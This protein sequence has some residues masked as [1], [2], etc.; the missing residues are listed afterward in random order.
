MV[1]TNAQINNFFTNNAQLAIPAETFDQLANEGITAPDDLT[2]FDK[3]TMK[4]VVE[5][6]RNPGGR[7]PNPDPN[8]PDG[9]TIARPPFV[10]GAKS[11]KRILE[12]CDIICFYETI[13][14]PLDARNLVY[15]TI[16]RN[17]AQQWKALKD[18][19]EAEDPELPKVT[20]ALPI[21]KWTEAFIDYCNRKIG[22]RTIPLSYVIR[23]EH[24]V[25]APAPPLATNLPHSEEH[26]SVKADLI[27]WASHN[28]PLYRDDNAKVY[29]DLERAL[30]GTSYLASIKPFQRARNGRDAYLAIRNQYAGQDKW[31]SE[32]KRQEDIVLNRVWKGQGNFT[33]DRFVG[34]HRN[35]FIMM[36]ECAEHVPY[37]LP[38][39][40]TR[41]THL[42]DNIQCDYAPLQAAMA[43]VRNDNT[44]PTGNTAGGKMHNFEDAVSFII[45]HDPVIKKRANAKRPQAN[46]SGA[47]GQ[48]DKTKDEATISSTS[49]KASK[50]KTGVEFRFYKRKEYEQLTGEQKHELWEWQKSNKSKK[51]KPS[52]SND[53]GKNKSSTGIAA[54]VAKE[55]ERRRE[56]EQ[57]EKE[58]EQKFQKYIMGIIANAKSDKNASQ[59]D[60][61]QVTINSILKRAKH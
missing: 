40:F 44:P 16:I 22:A 26:G 21:I 25:P 59:D 53:K 2:G 57:S 20:K 49:T 18:R 19:K 24:K 5:N 27:A 14:R 3:D 10:F 13:G 50:G 29:F 32:L 34:Q 38:N 6:L 36:Q 1:L 48:D 51:P 58:M 42:L 33:L 28:H 35:A 23:E 31:Q 17:F 9:S 52:P 54:V 8:A 61:R 30:R 45:P 11:H 46:I 15:S 41:V 37:Q 56:N 7:V 43:L 55:L 4:T 12:A 47:E 60:T 39:G